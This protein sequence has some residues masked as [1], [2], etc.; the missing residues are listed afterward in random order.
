MA[1]SLRRR[2]AFGMFI[3]YDI[4]AATSL[5]H[6][7]HTLLSL[8]LYDAALFHF[9]YLLRRCM[10]LAADAAGHAAA[11]AAAIYFDLMLRFFATIT[12]WLFI[13]AIFMP[14]V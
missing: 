3:Y 1:I 4:A 14:G 5:R 9:R 7:S 13:A 12:C 10:P 2:H 8:I 11:Y 6:F